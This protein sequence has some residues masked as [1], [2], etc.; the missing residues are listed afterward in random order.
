M[1]LT[2][3]IDPDL[4]EFLIRTGLAKP[5]STIDIAVLPGGVSCDVWKVA[6]GGQ[7]FVVKR[8]LPRLRVAKLWEAPIARSEAEWNWLNF[9]L[10]I[11]SSAVPR[12]LAHSAEAGMI[13]IEYLE[14]DQYPVWKQQLLDGVADP[15]VAAAVA[16][17]IARIHSASA[18]DSAVA[19]QFRTRESFYALRIEPYL[20]EAARQNPPISRFLN[21]LAEE[22]Q[23]TEIAL[24]HGDLSPKNIL[25]G[26]KG[27]VILD[28]ETAWYGDPAFDPAFC[29]NHLLLKCV[30]RPRFTDAYLTCFESF[31]ASYLDGVSWEETVQIEART[32]M[33][34]PALMLARVDGKSPVEYLDETQRSFV[35]NAAIELIKG[36]PVQLGA[37]SSRWRKKL[38]G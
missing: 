16:G 17:I 7:T 19:A 35:R 31:R 1:Q 20:L 2:R 18:G 28:A 15:S 21:R 6:A 34:L 33:L 26:R 9:A 14:P 37:I 27:P 3:Q 38:R 12:A 4:S 23:Q 36:Q 32:A 8:A 25:V 11:V 30:A 10:G 13:A 22:T 29:L 5:D 24:V